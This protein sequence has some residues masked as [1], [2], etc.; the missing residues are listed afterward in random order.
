[1]YS[2]AEPDKSSHAHSKVNSNKPNPGETLNQQFFAGIIIFIISI[3]EVEY[4]VQRGKC[5]SVPHRG[6]QYKKG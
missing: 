5:L 1:M 6:E 2:Y 3:T 4:I